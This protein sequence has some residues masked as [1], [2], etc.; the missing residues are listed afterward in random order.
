MSRIKSKSFDRVKS[1]FF[2]L[3]S[4]GERKQ[5]RQKLAT[6]SFTS[7]LLKLGKMAVHNECNKMGMEDTGKSLFLNDG[8]WETLNTVSSHFKSM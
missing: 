5:K 2:K 3:L 1:S 6:Q 4:G 7:Y 8:Y